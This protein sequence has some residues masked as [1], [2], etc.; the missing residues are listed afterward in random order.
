MCYIFLFYL[1]L[2]L[3]S[4]SHDVRPSLVFMTGAE[5]CYTGHIH[6]RPKLLLP[7]IVVLLFL[8]ACIAG[9]FPIA[10][11]TVPSP[12]PLTVTPLPTQTA[13]PTPLAINLTGAPIPVWITEFADPIMEAIAD[14]KP[15]FH[16]DFSRDRGWLNVISGFPLPRYADRQDG[17]LIL[18][19]SKGTHDSIFYNPRIDLKNFA[20]TFN[21]R[22]NH[23]QPNDNSTNPI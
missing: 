22:F 15:D 10:A 4:P 13:S 16:D 2:Y 23:D 11:S 6:M 19:L 12:E 21:L 18:K 5:G 1:E 9:N 20:L 17:A 14:R 8:L 3:F 7:I